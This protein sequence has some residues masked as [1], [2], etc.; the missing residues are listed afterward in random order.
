MWYYAAIIGW[1]NTSSEY[2]SRRGMP[3]IERVAARRMCG[4]FIE[5]T[6]SMCV[7]ER[8]SE[9]VRLMRR[10][11]QTHTHGIDFIRHVQ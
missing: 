6:C 3:P 11:T 7:R 4:L 5:I 9:R 8:K 10:Q 1:E 2:H